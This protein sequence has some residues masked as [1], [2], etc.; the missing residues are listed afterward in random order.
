MDQIERY[1]KA[2][3]FAID[4]LEMYAAPESYHAVMIVG[5]P[6]CG[7][8][9]YDFSFDNIYNRDMPGCK[10][11]I[12]LKVLRRAFGDLEYTPR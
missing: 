11:R 3:G 8:F 6:P 5:D 2:L 4:A 12:T 7:E 9:A 1:K 10:A